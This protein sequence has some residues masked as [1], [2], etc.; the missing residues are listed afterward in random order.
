MLFKA[1][2]SGIDLKSPVNCMELALANEDKIP[3]HRKN[4]MEK[5]IENNLFI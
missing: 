3:R 5:I 2:L 1:M 4:R